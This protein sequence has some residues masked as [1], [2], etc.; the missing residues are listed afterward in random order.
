M[1]V[2][3]Q[4]HALAL[5][6]ISLSHVQFLHSLCVLVEVRQQAPQQLLLTRTYT[7]EQLKTPDESKDVD[8]W[9]MSVI[10]NG[11]RALIA[12]ISNGSVKALDL[13]AATLSTLYKETDV[14]EVGNV[15]M[16]THTDGTQSLLVTERNKLDVYTKR[17]V[18]ADRSGAA[19]T[20]TRTYDITWKD[21]T[22]VRVWRGWMGASHPPSRTRPPH[23]GPSA[24]PLCSSPSRHHLHYSLLPHAQAATHL[25][26]PTRSGFY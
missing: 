22:D 8:I 9:G 23:P 11:G 15:C 20:F 17:V 25:P 19:G 18:V 13:D 24:L 7:H 6:H 14:W 12:D 4:L 16:L 5:E 26:C 1:R 10:Q 21:D 2:F 3:E